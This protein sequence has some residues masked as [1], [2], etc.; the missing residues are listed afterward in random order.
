MPTVAWHL[1]WDV[2]GFEGEGFNGTCNATL[3]Q[4]YRRA[5]YGAVSYQDYNIGRV[6]D[7]LEGLR[8]RMTTAV[9]VFGD[10]GW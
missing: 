2:K 10:H 5:Y 6:L 1:P 9:V 7:A 3:A 4:M 8:K